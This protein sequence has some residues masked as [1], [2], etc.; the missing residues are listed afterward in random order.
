LNNIGPESLGGGAGSKN[1]DA[2]GGEFFVDFEIGEN[3]VKAQTKAARDKG[4]HDNGEGIGEAAVLRVALEKMKDN[5]GTNSYEGGLGKSAQHTKGESPFLLGVVFESPEHQQ[6][7]QKRQG[8]K[9]DI[10]L[11]VVGAGG[12]DKSGIEAKKVS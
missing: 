9:A 1:E 12:L 3:S 8:E 7:K 5:N 10:V 6:M 4:D 2:A 11:G